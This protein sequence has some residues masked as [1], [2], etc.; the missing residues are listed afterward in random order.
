[1]NPSRHPRARFRH[2]KLQTGILNYPGQAHLHNT[3]EM[4]YRHLS[5][6]GRFDYHHHV[7]S[8]YLVHN[9]SLIV[10][11]PPSY[12]LSQRRYPVL[13]MHDGNNLFDPATAFMGREWQLDV[14]LEKC[15]YQRLLPEMIVVG[16]YNTPARLDEYT[17]HAHHHDGHPC[18]GGG[19]PYA[20]FI[21]EEL[22]PFI[23]SHY[24]SE[25]G[26]AHTAIM[27]SS[28]GA[29]ISFYT[30]ASYPELFSK[31]GMMSPTVYWA[32]H[33]ILKD[34]AA[35]PTHLR[36]WVDIGTEEGSNPHT[37]ET[38]ESTQLLVQALEKRGYV[39][40]VNLGFFIDYLVGHDE[41]AWG[42]RVDKALRFLFAG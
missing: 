2:R 36:L 30:A 25:S 40:N 41:W 19:K 13:Y 26:P 14:A 11:L 10:Y 31:V 42:N 35:L 33:Q 15:F 9:R 4:R 7:V 8:R 20:R 37:E 18:G 29:L 27:G 22:K 21:A 38:V 34:V 17:F 6:K 32:H 5:L 1:M 23:D 24:R 3:R 28:L 16:I 39:Q 12:D